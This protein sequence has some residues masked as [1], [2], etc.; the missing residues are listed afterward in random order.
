MAGK[1]D[2]LI[3]ACLRINYAIIRDVI[4]H[5]A[6]ARRLNLL[7]ETR[8]Q[9]ETSYNLWCRRINQQWP[10]FLLRNFLT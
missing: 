2:Q 4:R 8:N 1:R 7:K 6:P 9:V 3:H 10:P 5:M